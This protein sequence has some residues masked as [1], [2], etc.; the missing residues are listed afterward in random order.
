MGFLQWFGLFRRRRRFYMRFLGDQEEEHYAP[1]IM[2][3]ENR[4]SLLKNKKKKEEG[5]K[6]RMQTQDLSQPQ[7]VAKVGESQLSWPS[8]LSSYN[9]SKERKETTDLQLHTDG[10]SSQSLVKR[11]LLNPFRAVWPQFLEKKRPTSAAAH[12]AVENFLAGPAQGVDEADLYQRWCRELLRR[13]SAG[14][15]NIL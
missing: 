1:L 13:L 9:V 5:R 11:P 15:Q 2:H 3:P 10:D 6:M 12:A 4:K 14:N 8:S 7:K